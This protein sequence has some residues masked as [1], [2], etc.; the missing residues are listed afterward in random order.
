MHQVAEHALGLLL[1][2]IR[3]IAA[4]DRLVRQGIWD[5]HR[6]WPD[7]H[8]VG[9]TLGLIGFG[10]IARLVARKASGLELK[11]IACDPAYDAPTMAEHGVEKVSLDDLL[12]RSDFVSIHVPLSERTRHLIGCREL[13]LMKPQAV[14]INTA[15]GEVVDQ[16]ALVSAL[17]DRSIAAAGLDVLEEEPP[18]LDDPL[19]RLENVVLTPHIASYSNVFHERFWDHS[20]RTLVELSEKHWPLWAVNAELTPWWQDAK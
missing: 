4:Q 8:L 18:A 5:R 14:L 13:R 11:M 20:V 1:A 15:R 12:R 3:Q 16:R 17:E 6:A 10:R 19:L 2:V 9:Q 7:W